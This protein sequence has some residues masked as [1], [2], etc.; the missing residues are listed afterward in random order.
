MGVAVACVGYAAG[1]VVLLAVVY[2]ALLLRAHRNEEVIGSAIL[3]MRATLAQEPAPQR[4]VL[5]AVGD[6]VAAQDG[7]AARIE[8][9]IHEAAL[10]QGQPP[11]AGE[12]VEQLL[13]LP[14][15]Q[16]VITEF[17]TEHGAGLG[18][19]AALSALAGTMVRA[20]TAAAFGDLAGE[21][22]AG[23]DRLLLL[24]AEGSSA[25]VGRAALGGAVTPGRALRAPRMADSGSAALTA[26][27]R[28]LDHLTRRQLRLATLLHGQAE[29]M[30]RIRPAGPQPRA[31]AWLRARARQLLSL[32]RVHSP[33]F[34]TDDL[35]ALA[36]AL[37]AVGEVVDA[38][39]EQLA[40]GESMQA[41]HLLTGLRVPVPAGLP[42]RLYHQE[43]LAQARPLAAVG[44]RHRLEVCRWLAAIQPATAA[45]D[46]EFAASARPAGRDRIDEGR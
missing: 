38:A 10:G 9:A 8:A 42:G 11:L 18:P 17:L 35:S 37:D 23:L 12:L 28:A 3:A 44:I 29:A 2:L 20:A 14:E 41:V 31:L 36:V 27:A 15:P 34:G 4:A 30:L 26:V 46:L 24:A 45:S 25:A 33:R 6:I 16:Y 5:S 39:A 19:V 40:D 43:S 13:S 32:P 22:R 1:A 7:A 21:H